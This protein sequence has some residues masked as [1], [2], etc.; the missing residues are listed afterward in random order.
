MS[1]KKRWSALSHPCH[2]YETPLVLTLRL[3][4]PKDRKNSFERFRG[5]PGSD[6]DFALQMLV[7][8]Y[9]PLMRKNF[10]KTPE[11]Q[12]SLKALYDKTIRKIR[13]AARHNDAEFFRKWGR[14]CDALAAIDPDSS[15]DPDNFLLAANNFCTVGGRKTSQTAVMRTAID[16]MAAAIIKG[17]PNRI[18]TPGH[19]PTRQQLDAVIKERSLKTIGWRARI[20][21][22]GLTFPDKT[23]RGRPKGW[24]KR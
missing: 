17:V 12:K 8:L 21:K 19:Q 23:K 18:P 2:G 22:L 6:Q 11:E 1:E 24:R 7:G 16:F 4:L 14:G 20:Q 15:L 5:K 9:A 3:F 13:E 10:A